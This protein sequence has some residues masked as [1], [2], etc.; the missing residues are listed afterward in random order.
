MLTSIA[1][2]ICKRPK[3]YYDLVCLEVYKAS[4]LGENQELWDKNDAELR[5]VAMVEKRLINVKLSVMRSVGRRSAYPQEE[6]EKDYRRMR[7]AASLR[8]A[9]NIRQENNKAVDYLMVAREEELRTA[10]ELKKILC[11]RLCMTRLSKTP[12]AEKERFCGRL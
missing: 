4:R 1:K 11:A 9:R 10:F 5:T 2:I 12:K 8:Q 7:L 3:A 6:F